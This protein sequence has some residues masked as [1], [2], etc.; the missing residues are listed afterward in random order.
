MRRSRK[1]IL[2][3]SLVALVVA[4][5]IGGVVYAQTNNQNQATSRQEALLSKVCE[6]YQTN[7]GIALDPSQLKAAFSQ[8]LSAMQDE[9]VNKFLQA[10]VEKGKITQE[11]ADQ[12]KKWLESRPDVPIPFGPGMHRGFGGRGGFPGWCALP[13]ANTTD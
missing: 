7:T 12:Y 5:S 11:Q 1:I 6:I 8:A 3:V 9:D 4:G 2:I 13:S 10:L